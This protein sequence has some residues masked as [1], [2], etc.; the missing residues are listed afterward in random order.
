[1]IYHKLGNFS[2]QILRLNST[3]IQN[4]YFQIFF[5]VRYPLFKSHIWDFCEQEFNIYSK[6]KY[7]FN[8]LNVPNLKILIK[9]ANYG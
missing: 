4:K 6:K 3:Y 5:Y 8:F 9:A 2:F 7:K 1:M